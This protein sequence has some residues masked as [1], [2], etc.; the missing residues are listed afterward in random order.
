[1]ALGVVEVLG[2]QLL[3]IGPVA[4]VEGAEDL[5]LRVR[6]G[7]W[8]QRGLAITWN[9]SRSSASTPRISSSIRGLPASAT[10]SW[11]NRML[12]VPSAGQVLLVEGP[13]ALVHWGGEAVQ[14]GRRI[15]D[16]PAVSV[17]VAT[18]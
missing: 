18:N 1:M 5:P 8:S 17:V 13:L 16:S 10:I 11:W 7:S 14:S 2:E 12:A 15:D 4:L 3:G 6:L 9:T